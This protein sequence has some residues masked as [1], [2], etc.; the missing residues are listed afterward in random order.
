MAAIYTAIAEQQIIYS[1]IPASFEEY[2]QR[3]RLADSVMAQKLGTCLDMALLYASCLEAIGLNALIV[4]T[5]G[6]AFAGAWLVPETFPDPTIDDVSLLTKRTAEGIYD[7]T[8]VETTCMNMGHSSDFDDAVKKANGKLTD[9]NN[10]LLAIDI[11]RAR[12]SGVRPIPQ[13]ILHG[14]VWEIDEKETNIQNNAVHATPQSINPYDLSGNETQTV[15]TKQLLW[16]RRLLDLSLRNNLL[17]IRITKNT[18]QLIPAN[19]ACLEDALADGEEFRIL[20]RP[21]DWES[22]A[23]DFGI[24]S[25]VPEFDPVV[26]FINSELSQKRLRFY[27]PENDLG[28]ALT[29]LYRSSRTSIEENGANT[30]YLALGL[31][32]WYETPSS[33][34]P[35]YAPILLMPVEIIRKSAAKG[36]VIRSREE[37]TMMNI[38][39]NPI[40]H[41]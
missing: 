25:S 37:E 21:A 27:L 35:R 30:L 39:I 8:L 26:G 12:Y 23:I 13:R 16:E 6:H 11:K 7:I 34:R 19:L 36:Y 20:H 18:L 28:K 3:V 38:R 14:Q 40:A 29:H 22:P 10:F 32:K 1:T 9:R 17:N 4:I 31:L 24:Y 15:I 2:G 41:R 5:Q 33:E